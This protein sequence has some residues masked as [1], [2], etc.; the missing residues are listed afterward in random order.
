MR[1]VLSQLRTPT[2]DADLRYMA[3]RMQG[4]P[5]ELVRYPRSTHERSRCRKGPVPR[6]R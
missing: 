3:L 1:K 2:G 4:V 6:D 5:M